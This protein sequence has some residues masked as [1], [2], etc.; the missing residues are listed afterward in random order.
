MKNI[1]LQIKLSQKSLSTLMWKLSHLH[2]SVYISE[3][4][5]EKDL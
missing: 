1:S 4:D 5:K 2:I 3:Q